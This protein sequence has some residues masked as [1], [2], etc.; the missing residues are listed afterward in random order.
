MADL[1][2]LAT[3]NADPEVMEHFPCALTTSETQALIERIEMCFTENGYGLWAVEVVQDRT[4]AGFVGLQPVGSELPF[5]PAV[6]I[7]WRLARSH[8]RR[9]YA[10]E[11]ASAAIAFGFDRL[12]L[13]EIVSF[14]TVGNLRSRRL[15]ERLGMTRD[16]REDFE[17]PLVAPDSRLR[18]HVLYRLTRQTWRKAP[19]RQRALQ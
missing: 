5:C 3:I 11:A 4:L 15:M 12:R 10:A 9:G 17:H 6:E 13:Q 8:W 2:P 19:R 18:A 1:S 7:G 14:T 16:P